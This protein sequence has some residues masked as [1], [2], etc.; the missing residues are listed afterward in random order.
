M[1]F[2]E[3]QRVGNNSKQAALQI[4]IFFMSSAWTLLS[5]ERDGAVDNRL[6]SGRFPSV[7]Q[8]LTIPQ[9][10]KYCLF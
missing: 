5:V 1:Y 10:I 4:I 9:E 8:L 2:D 7:D 6:C 3:S